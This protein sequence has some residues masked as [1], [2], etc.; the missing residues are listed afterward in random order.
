[1]VLVRDQHVLDGSIV[2]ECV[3]LERCLHEGEVISVLLDD[4]VVMN[5]DNGSL[6]VTEIITWHKTVDSRCARFDLRLEIIP[7]S[8]KRITSNNELPT[9]Q[10]E[11]AGLLRRLVYM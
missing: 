9:R 10:V 3:I 1:M 2:R 8:H 4:I 6:R 11:R 5:I 7:V